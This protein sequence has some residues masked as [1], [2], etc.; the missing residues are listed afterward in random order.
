MTALH[1]VSFG[2]SVILLLTWLLSARKMQYPSRIVFFP[3]LC[4]AIFHCVSIVIAALAHNVESSS[5]SCFVST[6]FL[7]YFWNATLCW[8]AVLGYNT[9]KLLRPSFYDK[10]VGRSSEPLYHLI[11]WLCP[12]VITIFSSWSTYSPQHVW[13]H[14][15]S[16]LLFESQLYS[17]DIS[18]AALSVIILFLVCSIS[19]ALSQTWKNLLDSHLS[20]EEVQRIVGPGVRIIVVLVTVALGCLIGSVFRILAAVSDA[21]VSSAALVVVDRFLNFI[22]GVVGM[23]MFVFIGATVENGR[24]WLQL[25]GLTRSPSPSKDS[26]LSSSKI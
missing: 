8:L 22:C 5:R 23:V 25:C 9:C 15:S 12:L 1:S 24:I 11:A 3:V 19:V 14:V 17:V 26:L 2:C 18:T 7:S 21:T 13:C 16:G 20:N 4:S 6:R 10:P